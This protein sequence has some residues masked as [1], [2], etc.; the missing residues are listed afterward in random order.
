[1]GSP[2]W[3]AELEKTVRRLFAARDNIARIKPYYDR[4]EARLR[5]LRRYANKDNER[6]AVIWN[7]KHPGEP[8]RPH[9]LP[10]IKSTTLRHWAVR[11]RNAR[12]FEEA[13]VYDQGRFD[14]ELRK[15]IYLQHICSA[16]IWSVESYITK[17]YPWRARKSLFGGKLWDDALPERFQPR[18]PKLEDPIDFV[19]LEEFMEMDGVDLFSLEN[20]KRDGGATQEPERDPEQD[21]G[22][23]REPEPDGDSA[24]GGTSW[25]DTPGESTPPGEADT[26]LGEDDFP[27]DASGRWLT[28]HGYDKSLMTAHSGKATKDVREKCRGA[29]DRL[30]LELRSVPP[31]QHV[32]SSPLPSSKPALTDQLLGKPEATDAARYVAQKLNLRRGEYDDEEWE[33]VRVLYRSVWWNLA[34]KN[35]GNP[36]GHKVARRLR[37]TKFGEDPAVIRPYY[38]ALSA[39]YRSSPLLIPI[40]LHLAL[41]CWELGRGLPNVDYLPSEMT[42][43]DVAP[44]SREERLIAQSEKQ[45]A[46]QLRAAGVA[47]AS[48][49]TPLREP[50]G[51]AQGGDRPGVS[52]GSGAGGTKRKTQTGASLRQLPEKTIRLTTPAAPRPPATASTLGT[53]TALRR[54][55]TKLAPPRLGAASPQTRPPLGIPTPK[56]APAKTN[57]LTLPPTPPSGMS[58]WERMQDLRAGR[59]Q[60]KP[61]VLQPG[62]NDVFP[63]P[64]GEPC[65]WGEMAEWAKA[66]EYLTMEGV[67]KSAGLDPTRYDLSLLESVGPPSV[68]EDS[69]N[70]P[71]EESETLQ[72]SVE[73]ILERERTRVQ[74][75]SEEMYHAFVTRVSTKLD[76]VVTQTGRTMEKALSEMNADAEAFKDEMLREVQR[77]REG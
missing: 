21:G 62:P 48:T 57:D 2:S 51:S 45:D 68:G 4:E 74:Q 56:A 39:V 31:H 44:V 10:P 25:E 24:V 77:F 37:S 52:G 76:K 61:T 36:G 23:A 53:P 71:L 29:L 20:P 60:L 15:G 19:S 47:C 9:A 69:G 75:E 49:D 34:S 30:K 22:A 42:G 66:D 3:E 16:F 64:S 72:E 17:F 54:T 65:T 28:R 32:P 5:E 27:G 58:M 14:R 50:T 1:V 63:L 6:R 26:A 11:L 59:I 55:L 13:A 33:A 41:R 73:A 40:S 70:V 67:M 7:K 18:K 43:F 8:F 38:Y 12:A 35:S 46:D